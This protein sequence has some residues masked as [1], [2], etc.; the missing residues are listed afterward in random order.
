V[1][2]LPKQ[3]RYVALLRAVNLG[4]RNKVPMARL[5][6]VLGQ[7]GC[8]NVRTYIASG[9]VLLDSSETKP[10]LTNKLEATIEREF[11][12]RTVAVVLTAADLAKV[13]R[14][15][16]FNEAVPG[17]VHVAFA[18]SALEPDTVKA[19]TG[20]PPT[21]DDK[22]VV[23]GRQIYFH[24]PGGFGAAAGAGLALGK[25]SRR[26]RSAPGAQSSS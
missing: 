19:L 18:A 13:V 25:P 20:L 11:N 24:L 26:L 22:V 21:A 9:N 6:E 1:A 8:D 2:K 23:D 16:P 3:T 15:N 7:E 5:R 4:A 14:R 12:L 10:T 17:T